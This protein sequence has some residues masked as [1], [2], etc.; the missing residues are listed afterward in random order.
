MTDS[1]IY[2]PP[3]VLKSVIALLKKGCELKDSTSCKV[4]FDA[5]NMQK[6]DTRSMIIEACK[7]NPDFCISFSSINPSLSEELNNIACDSNILNA[8]LNKTKILEE[9]GVSKNTILALYRK[10]CSLGD[11]ESCFKVNELL[12]NSDEEKERINIQLYSFANLSQSRVSKCAELF[13]LNQFFL[14]T[15]KDSLTETKSDNNNYFK[16]ELKLMIKLG[17]NL[18]KNNQNYCLPY[19]KLILD[20]FD[21]VKIDETESEL[22]NKEEFFI[23][24]DNQCE[25]NNGEA[26]F[27]LARL[28]KFFNFNRKDFFSIMEKSCSLGYK[29][30]CIKT[31]EIK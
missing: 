4:L 6:I 2:N 19:A 18:C 22:L 9:R 3:R 31:K 16:N 29:K 20:N 8:C 27:F 13:E 12:E 21:L 30:S 5:K 14:N 17:K 11:G 28:L 24:F 23:F 10:N 15:E 25:M 26:C 1:Q 7:N